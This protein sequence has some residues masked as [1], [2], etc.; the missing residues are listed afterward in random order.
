MTFLLVPS[1]S[2]VREEDLEGFV[3][4]TVFGRTEVANDNPDFRY[5]GICLGCQGEQVSNDPDV[6]CLRCKEA[7]E[8]IDRELPVS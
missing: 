3:N 5:Q 2:P 4:N 7:V 1:Q 8:Y 6:P